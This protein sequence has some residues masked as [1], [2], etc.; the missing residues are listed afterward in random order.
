MAAIPRKIFSVSVTFPFNNK[1]LDDSGV[2]LQ[3]T[4]EKKQNSVRNI[5]DTRPY[6]FYFSA[7]VLIKF[8]ERQ[9]NILLSILKNHEN[10]ISLALKKSMHCHE[11]R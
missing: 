5:R 7:F 1:Y 4:E 11:N 6:S 9:N 2:N 8:F 10:L 3:E